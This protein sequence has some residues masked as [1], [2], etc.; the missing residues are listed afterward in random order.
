VSS[1]TDL[2]SLQVTVS[3]GRLS[4]SAGFPTCLRALA[5]AA[6][7]RLTQKPKLQPQ[8]LQTILVL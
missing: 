2:T 1:V 7:D 6:L 5:K 8:E 4:L 3:N